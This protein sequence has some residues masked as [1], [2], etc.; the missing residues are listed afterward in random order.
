MKAEGN[1][2][3]PFSQGFAFPEQKVERKNLD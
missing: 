1:F 2:F 3:A